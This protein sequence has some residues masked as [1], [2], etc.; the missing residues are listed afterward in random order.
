M[1]IFELCLHVAEVSSRKSSLLHS[2]EAAHGN[3]LCRAHFPTPGRDIWGMLAGRLRLL[4]FSNQNRDSQ[5]AMSKLF[6][7]TFRCCG[8]AAIVN[9]SKYISPFGAWNEV[10]RILRSPLK[11]QRLPKCQNQFSVLK[12]ESA[13]WTMKCSRTSGPVN[14]SPK[15]SVFGTK[16]EFKIESRRHSLGI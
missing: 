14:P 11:R 9:S 3:T 16:R 10:R 5:V 12:A 7:P 4:K 8:E 13:F 15:S 1:N 6:I 2:C